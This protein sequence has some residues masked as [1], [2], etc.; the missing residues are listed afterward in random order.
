MAGNLTCKTVLCVALVASRMRDYDSAVSHP[1]VQS[2]ARLICPVGKTGQRSLLQ[3]RTSRSLCLT[4]RAESCMQEP[5][6]GRGGVGGACASLAD[7][8]HYLSAK[9]R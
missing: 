6:G 4:G 5:T 2:L 7:G 9:S 3:C 1:L 8:V